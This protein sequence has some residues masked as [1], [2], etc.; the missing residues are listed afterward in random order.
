MPSPVDLV[1][2]LLAVALPLLFFFRESIPGIG[3]RKRAVVDDG[4]ST[5]SATGGYE[6]DPR[7]FVEKMDKMVR[8]KLGVICSGNVD[9]WR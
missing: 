8:K 5:S 6:G 2:I 1:I 9:P 4:P 7:D 3:G